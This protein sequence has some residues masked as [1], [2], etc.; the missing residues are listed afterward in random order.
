MN[1]IVFFYA[2]DTGLMASAKHTKYIL[3][4]LQSGLKS[5]NKFLKKWKIQLNTAKTQAMMFPFNNSP[6][7]KPTTPLSF[8]GEEIKF[9]KTATYFGIELDER[10]NFVK[11]AAEKASKC[12]KSIYP[13]LA[14]KLKLSLHNKNTL[15][16]SMIRPI[17]TY[18]SPVWYK[19]A[20]THIKKL[21]I[22]QNKSLKLINKP[23]QLPTCKG[24]RY[25]AAFGV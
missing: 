25:I 20:F 3:N 10:T 9:S 22:I 2:D 8:E 11:V 14:K 13:L 7:R 17:M 24:L 19:T 16:K 6:K 18:G 12:V 15:Y 1:C 21:Q 23:P 5:S 4:K